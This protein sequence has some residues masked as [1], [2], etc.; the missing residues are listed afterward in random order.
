MN[1]AFRL[2][3]DIGPAPTPSPFMSSRPRND[4]LLWCLFCE[5]NHPDGVIDP[6]GVGRYAPE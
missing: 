4:E 1:A 3:A 6:Y 2:D 5:N